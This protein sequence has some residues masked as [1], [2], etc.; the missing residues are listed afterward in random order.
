M[1]S[2]KLITCLKCGSDACYVQEVNQDIN[3]YFCYGCGF[4][5]NTLM[6]EGE[7]LM[8]EQIKLLPELY[9]D[10]KFEDKNGQVW[11]PSTIN[12]TEQGMVFANGSTTD[13]W[14]W[15]AVKSIEVTEE[16]KEKYPIPGKKGKYYK[17]RMDMTT[18]KQFKERDYM[19][20]LSYIGVLPS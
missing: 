12:L 3:N 13:N 9:K 11:F 1:N 8:D 4:Q 5:S 16:E 19:E 14:M 15:A 10:L 6:R 7:E 20:A 18:M 17:H 2:D